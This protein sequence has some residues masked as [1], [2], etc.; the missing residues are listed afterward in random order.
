M[1]WLLLILGLVALTG[2]GM[3]ACSF[4]GAS[5]LLSQGRQALARGDY[6]RTQQLAAELERDERR[7][8]A[9]LLRGLTFVSEARLRL[10]RAAT[11]A[12]QDVVDQTLLVGLEAMARGAAA[13]AGSL[14]FGLFEPRMLP[15][16]AWRRSRHQEQALEAA[17]AQQ[18]FRRARNELREI[19]ES[20]GLFDEAAALSGECLYHLGERERSAHAFRLV[21]S[22]NAQRADVHRWLAAIYVDLNAARQAIEHLRAL[23]H[24]DPQDGRP[25]RQLGVIHKDF[26][27]FEPAIQA[28]REAMQRPLEPVL[29]GEVIQELAELLVSQ[30]RH[31]EAA[32]ALARCPPHLAGQAEHL[33]LRAEVARELGQRDDAIRLSDAALQRDGDWPPALLLRGTLHL[34]AGE[35]REAAQL[36]ER[37]VRLQPHDQRGRERLAQVYE[38]LGDRERAALH[39]RLKEE[40]VRLQTELTRLNREALVK[41]WDAGVRL[42]L[43]RV[44]LQM[45]RPAEARTW[46]RATLSCNPQHQE[47]RRVLLQLDGLRPD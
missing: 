5:D 11:L 21:L 2:L 12:R 26:H 20:S 37:A 43:A 44:W 9:A 38:R 46:L 19:S 17:R 28:Y 22:R 3:L 29:L 41:P 7:E 10:G 6:S 4:L 24:L 30:G 27:Q 8:E 13:P 31:S 42:Q 34:E 15:G 36:L 32:E 23:A 45:E 16:V 1:K 33:A 39:W 47:A 18:A 40:S 14:A 35:H 25:L